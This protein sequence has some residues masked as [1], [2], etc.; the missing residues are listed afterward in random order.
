MLKLE[1]SSAD[2]DLRLAIWVLAESNL[3]KLKRGL[4]ILLFNTVSER[5]WQAILY[6][7]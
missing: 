5:V 3:R 7:K 2:L 4:P 1:I 6:W